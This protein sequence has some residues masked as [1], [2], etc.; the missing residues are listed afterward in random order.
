MRVSIV[1]GVP[2]NGWFIEKILLKWMIKIDLGV[3]L[4]QEPQYRNMITNSP[5]ESPLN[6]QRQEWTKTYPKKMLSGG[7]GASDFV[8]TFLENTR[9]Y[10]RYK[11]GPPQI[12]SLVYKP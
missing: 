8:G 1:M 2:E 4:F 6:E 11:M 3:P 10:G 7:V 5:V 9:R 12:W